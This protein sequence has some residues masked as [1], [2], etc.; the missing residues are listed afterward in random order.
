VT[1][2][3]FFTKAQKHVGEET[4]SIT[5]GAGDLEIHICRWKLKPYLQKSF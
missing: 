4:V 3:G 2:T 5:N 1:T